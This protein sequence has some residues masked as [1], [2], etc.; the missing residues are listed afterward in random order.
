M[1]AMKWKKLGKIFDPTQ[2]KLPNDCTHFAHRRRYC[3]PRFCAHLFLDE[4][5]RQEQEISEPHRFR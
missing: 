3:I 4:I 1:S 5:D 2:H